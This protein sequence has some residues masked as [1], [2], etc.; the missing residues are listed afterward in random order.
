M[1]PQTNGCD[2][3]DEDDFEW[4]RNAI[5]TKCQEGDDYEADEYSDYDFGSLQQ[6]SLTISSLLKW[7]PESRVSAQQAL[8]YIEWVDYRNEA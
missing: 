3:K 8:S 4:R 5:I 6:L 7:E 2:R 1:N